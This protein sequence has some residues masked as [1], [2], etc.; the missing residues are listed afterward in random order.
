MTYHIK[1]LWAARVHCVH[2][3]QTQF[4]DEIKSMKFAK[5]STLADSAGGVYWLTLTFVVGLVFQAAS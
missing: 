5:F 3:P 2:S 4:W 1:I